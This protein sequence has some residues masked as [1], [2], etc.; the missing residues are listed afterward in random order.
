MNKTEK[1]YKPHVKVIAVILFVVTILAFFIMLEILS[2]LNSDIRY[3]QYYSCE[4]T[5]ASA[6]KQEDGSYL[7]TL[8]IKNN[9]AYQAYIYDSSV[10]VEANNITLQNML[11]G[12]LNG[13]LLDS[14]TRPIVPSG[15]TV[16]Y[17]LQVLPPAGA[18]SVRIHYYGTSYSRYSVTNEDRDSV[19]T[20]KLS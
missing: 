5:D 1:I 13:D 7:I 8:R 16:E 2:E 11:K 12:E 17:K 6:E 9:S 14:L 10:W 18:A 4:I 19:F 20:I 3:S 15:Q